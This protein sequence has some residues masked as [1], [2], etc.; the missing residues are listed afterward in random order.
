MYKIFFNRTEIHIPDND[1]NKPGYCDILLDIRDFEN[2]KT[3]WLNDW[4]KMSN[5]KICLNCNDEIDCFGEFSRQFENIEAAGGIVLS[6]EGNILLIK[7][8]GIWD[9][10]K[11][12]KEPGEKIE[13]LALREVA[14]ETGIRHLISKGFFDS[15]YHI[16][17][18]YGAWT[19]KTTYWFVME[20]S[21]NEFEPQTEEGIEK[22]IFASKST[23]VSL[24]EEMYP[25]IYE[26][27]MKFFEKWEL[28]TGLSK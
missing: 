11:G 15:T 26:L 8:N 19:L 9:L 14:E 18:T 13:N 6:P 25:L 24:K 21:D 16:Y 23:I 22:V 28:K 17:D 20:T 10:P 2:N 4:R 5:I 1:G 27:L 7:R 3:E 12:K